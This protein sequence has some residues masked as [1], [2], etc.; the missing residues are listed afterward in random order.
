MAL[1]VGV[2]ME[3][4]IRAVTDVTDVTALLYSFPIRKKEL[5][6]GVTSVTSVT[7][8][9]RNRANETKYYLH[10]K[11]RLSKTALHEDKDY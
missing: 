10:K 9:T 3:E 1:L 6:N 7:N 4:I 2:K 8:S 11:R 5:R